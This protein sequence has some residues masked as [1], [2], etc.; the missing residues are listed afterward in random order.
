MIAASLTFNAYAALSGAVIAA[1]AGVGT[2]FVAHFAGAGLVLDS[3][4]AKLVFDPGRASDSRR[5]QKL[6]PLPTK[7]VSE[8][9]LRTL[10]NVVQEVSIAANI[11][12]PATYLIEDPDPNGPFG[13]K[14]VGQGPL[15]PVMPAV[16]NAVYDA[17]G[18][19]VRELPI[20]SEKVLRGIRNRSPER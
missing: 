17:T 10:V 7:E 13:A 16:A 8:A 5:S 15:L 1:I 20:T 11:R 2:A 9:T 14:E 4:G 3:T 18:V 12:P 19:R 6:P